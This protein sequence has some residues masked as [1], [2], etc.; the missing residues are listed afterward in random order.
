MT[1]LDQIIETKRKE[2]EQLKNERSISYFESQSNFKRSTYS[3]KNSIR[4]NDFGIIGEL[5]RKSPSAG[6]ILPEMDLPLLAKNYVDSGIC[7]ISCLTDLD[8]FGGSIY[9]LQQLRTLVQLPILRK[10]FIIDYIQIFE[11]KAAGADAILLIA[12]V[13]TKKEIKEFVRIA[14]D[15]NLEVL[16]EVH[17]LKEIDKMCGL[18]DLVGVN[19][20][21]L[22]LQ[23]TDLSISERLFNALPSEKLKISESG[24]KTKNDIDFLINIGYNGALIGESILKQSTPEQFISQLK[25]N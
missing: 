5:K 21:D 10:E 16:F 15:L 4:K 22:H 11:A 20:R 2:V 17:T 12:S 19:N 7:G 8:Y 14:H 6:P 13:L 9:D 23:K 18:E 3:L 1:I 25:T 24:I